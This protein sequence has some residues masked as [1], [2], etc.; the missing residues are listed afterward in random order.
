[1][2]DRIANINYYV[3]YDL[4]TL[5]RQYHT[6]R[7][8]LPSLVNGSSRAGMVVNT[9]IYV[10]NIPTVNVTRITIQDNAV[11][12]YNAQSTINLSQCIGWF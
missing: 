11:S 3:Q 5:I 4:V 12:L 10:I 6:V 1:M 7:R 8:R 9:G 2:D